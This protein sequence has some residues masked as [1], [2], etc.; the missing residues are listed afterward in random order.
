MDLSP[1]P[2]LKAW[3][4]RCLDRPAARA[5]LT[6]KT[7]SDN[8]TPADVTRRIARINRL[9]NSR[10]FNLGQSLN[11]AVALQRQGQLREAEKIYSRVLKAVPDNFDALNLLGA[12]KLQQGQIG[13]AQRLLSAAVKANPRAAGTWCNLGQALHALK[14][15]P[16]AL[17]CLDKARALAPGRP[18]HSQSACQCADHAGAAGGGAGGIPAS[19]G[20]RA[21][22]R[23]GA[24]Q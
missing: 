19:A 7:K 5:A 9:M 21:E 11:E 10:P 8:A 16:E 4:V 20:A 13:E 15:A 18:Q 3:L 14:R 17:D 24:A 6:L 1:W 22:P 23:R 2:H 12:V